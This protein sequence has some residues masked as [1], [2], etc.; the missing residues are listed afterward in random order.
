M[1]EFEGVLGILLLA[2]FLAALARRIGAPYPAFL[3]LVGAV[4][5]FVPGTPRFSIDP[6][7]ALALFVAPVLLDAAY[8]S[9][10]RDLKDNWVAVT[11]LA[12]V[13]VLFT[14]AAVALVARRLV[15]AMPWAA[16]IALGAIVSP[17]DAAAA[18]AVL[19]QLKPPHRILTILEGES[20]LNDAT[21][22][23]IYRLAVGAVAMSF[24]SVRA[25]VPTILLVV[26]GSI[27]AGLLL[28]RLFLPL[29]EKIRD[30]PTAIIIQF[31]STFG[32]WIL[33]D[34]L[35]LSS[36]LTMVAYAITVARRAPERTPAR[37]RLPSYA[38]WETAVF[39]LN[40][41]AFVFIGLQI[42]PILSG[43]EPA[44]RS[45]YLE[46]AGSV[47]L[48]VILVRILWVMTHNSVAR[49]WIRSHGFHPRRPITPPTVGSGIAISWSGMRGIVTLAAALA[50]PDEG[51]GAPFPFRDLIIVTAFSVVLGTLVVQ[52]LTLKPLLRLLDLRDD[53]PVGRETG[54]ARRRALEAALTTLEGDDS[55]AAEAVRHELTAHLASRGGESAAAE[56][57]DSSHENLHRRALAAAR[58]VAFDMRSR[59]DIGDDAFH[60]IEEELDW[61]EMGSAGREGA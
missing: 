2:A 54:A 21:A 13:S 60:R 34:R 50:L 33:A 49:W 3:A 29:I 45:R 36:I 51:S 52:G 15:P 57:R 16:A 32:V 30:V 53:D 22:L 31:V 46:V 44:A 25:V 23:L 61:L 12:V 9:S 37:I 5:A 56:D 48:A 41:L 19:R 18:V 38:V 59:D 28:A 42:R 8:D 47:L 10:P 55:T 24:F 40:V 7:M 6:E 4:L 11:S 26:A 58:R 27:A 17:P 43:L 1:S 14:T 35:G 20:L 39:V